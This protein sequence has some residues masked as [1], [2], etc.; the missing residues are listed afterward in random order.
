MFYGVAISKNHLTVPIIE[1]VHCRWCHGKISERIVALR[2]K[3][4]SH[5]TPTRR[6]RS[7][8]HEG[9]WAEAIEVQIE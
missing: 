3:L 7:D 9:C 6:Y 5:D 1:I 2:I 8:Y 4:S